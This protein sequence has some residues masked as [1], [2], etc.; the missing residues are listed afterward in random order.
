MLLYP[1]TGNIMSQGQYDISRHRFSVLI[2]AFMYPYFIF[3]PIYDL[4][5]RFNVMILRPQLYN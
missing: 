2:T 1:I 4:D 5:I 3:M